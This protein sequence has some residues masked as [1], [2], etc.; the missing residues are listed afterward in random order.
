MTTTLK[1]FTTANPTITMDVVVDGGAW[2]TVCT[3]AQTYRLFEV[4]TPGVEECTVLYRAKLK[5]EGLTGKAYLEMW[6][7][8]PGRG[9]FFS[10]GLSQTVT[11]SHDWVAGEIPFHLR[12]GEKPDLIR[13]NL[14]VASV[15]WIWKKPVAGRVWIKDVQLL[16]TP[17]A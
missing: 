8:L 15:G 7:R 3:K 13:L 12:K 9:E 17:R 1:T 10:K 11:G 14:V 4:L 5:T 16:W 6:C 2:L